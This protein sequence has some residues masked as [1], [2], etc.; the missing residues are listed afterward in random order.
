MVE[1][2]NNSVIRRIYGLLD[3]HSFVELGAGVTARST[4]F[5]AEGEKPS[6]DGVLTGHGLVDGRLVFVFSQDSEVLG[7]SIGEMHAKKICAIYDLAM[8][9]GAPVIGFFDSSGLRVAESF[10]ASE[11]LG[12]MIRKASEASGVI[13][14]VSMIFGNCGGGLSVFAGLADFVYMEEG[15]KFFINS[16]DAIPKNFREK[17]DTATAVYQYETAGR[18][19]AIGAEDE[20]L[21]K[22]RRLVPILPGSSREKGFLSESTDDLNRGAAELMQKEGNASEVF[23]EISDDYLFIPFKGGFAKEMSAGLIRLGGQTVG[24]VGNSIKTADG[25]REPLLT[26]DGADKAAEFIRF[27]D[28]FGIPVLSYVNVKGYDR[29]FEGEK[30]LPRALSRLSTAFATA[31]VPKITVYGS[32]AGGSAYLLMNAKSMGADIVYSYPDSKMFVMEG[33]EAAAILSTKE[34]P[35]SAMQF[36]QLAGGIENAVRRGYIDRIVSHADL[37]KYLIAGF[38]MLYSKEENGVYRKHSAK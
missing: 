11:A 17:A 8:K 2:T 7:G 6:S 32:I 35:I 3:E 24:A 29:S 10:D 12:A 19:D 28:S 14:Q 30:Y 31:S 15:A 38:E 4:D 26:A 1:A 25:E 9:T 13:P 33:K 22:V 18:V 21:A 36:D 20:I 23:E 34:K 37:R 16:P 27:C 5:L